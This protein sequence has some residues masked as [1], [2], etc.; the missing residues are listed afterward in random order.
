MTAEAILVGEDSDSF[1]SFFV[2]EALKV[3]LT[4]DKI[5]SYGYWIM[6]LI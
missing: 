2:I 5:K 6:M 1:L 4:I 3:N